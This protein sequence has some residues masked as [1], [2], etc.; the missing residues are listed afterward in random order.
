MSDAKGKGKDK[1]KDK[2]EADG[3]APKPSKLPVLLSLVNIL[4]TG[5]VAALVFTTAG[6]GSADEEVVDQSVPPIP[7]E[8][9]PFVVNLNEPQS[10]R[11]LKVKIELEVHG[12]E[13]KAAFE[14]KQRAI[15]SELLRYLSNLTVADTMGE[16]KKEAINAA[17]IARVEDHLGKETI[18]GLYLTEFVVQ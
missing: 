9:Q 13:R 12:E 15:R 4:A 11:Y 17:L 1:D 6:P 7:V 3:Q 14:A 18:A 2:E 16:D 10:S 5:G 8:M